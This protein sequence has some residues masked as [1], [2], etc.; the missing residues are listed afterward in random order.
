[1]LAAFFYVAAS[2]VVSLGAFFFGLWLVRTL[3]A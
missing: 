3:L 1:M 2:L